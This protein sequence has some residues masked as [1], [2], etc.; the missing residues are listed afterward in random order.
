[1]TPSFSSAAE[2]VLQ[3]MRL[4]GT[5]CVTRG[6]G[7]AATGDAYGNVDGGGAN[8]SVLNGHNVH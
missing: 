6:A 8:H 4:P 3:E 7:P 1:M 5:N 2:S